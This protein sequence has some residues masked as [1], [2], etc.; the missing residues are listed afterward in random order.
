MHGC[1]P[2]G[3]GSEQSSALARVSLEVGGETTL[4]QAC[5]FSTGRNI[6]EGLQPSPSSRKHVSDVGVM[7]QNARLITNTRKMGTKAETTVR[8]PRHSLERLQTLTCDHGHR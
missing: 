6:C 3:G 1:R 2:D 7:I 8:G 4:E 5:Q